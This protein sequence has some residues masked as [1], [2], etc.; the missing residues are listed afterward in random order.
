MAY[1]IRLDAKVEEKIRM[2]VGQNIAAYPALSQPTEFI[3]VQDSEHGY[4]VTR[5]YVV[6]RIHDTGKAWTMVFVV[7]N[8]LVVDPFG[9]QGSELPISKDVWTAKGMV[10]VPPSV[11]QP[12][13]RHRGG[14]V[15]MSGS[16]HRQPRQFSKQNVSS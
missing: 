1:N 2:L 14:K 5:V 7:K 12:W 4:S 6:G 11:W 10:P 3:T 16:F 8:S 13:E 9:L 15:I